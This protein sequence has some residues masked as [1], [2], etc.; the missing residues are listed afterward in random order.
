MLCT[1]RMMNTPRRGENICKRKDGRW[2]ARYIKEFTV[3]GKKK[4]GSVYAQSY[5]EVKAKQ[6]QN[7]IHPKTE[8]CD[9]VN[10]TVSILMFKWL[11]SIK[12]QVKPN[13]YQK[14]ES[15][16]RNHIVTEIGSVLVRLVSNYTIQ[17]FT[18]RLLEN[19]LSNKTV[20]DILI[21]LNLAF[22]YK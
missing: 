20:N 16:S 6:Q 2:E 12:N 8:T 14:Y 4:Y 3:D 13:T 18:N 5:K 11:E 17:N 9:S 1:E 22:R 10:L 15:I 19:H 7:L 21:I